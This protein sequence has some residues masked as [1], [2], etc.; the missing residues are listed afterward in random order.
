MTNTEIALHVS[1]DLRLAD[2]GKLK[3]FADVT[4]ALGD[5]GTLTCQGYSVFDDSAEGPRVAP[6][7]RKGNS[8]YFDVVTLNGEIRR[9]VE[10]AVIAE[11]ERQKPS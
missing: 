10:A 3:A 2:K 8:R 11:Y 4:I 7:A 9:L 6:P 5:Y 1:V